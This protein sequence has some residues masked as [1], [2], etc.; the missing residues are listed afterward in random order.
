MADLLIRNIEPRLKR[1]IAESARKSRHSLSE[2]AKA[3]IQRGLATHEPVTKMGSFLF[4]LFE[5]RD[6]GD[7][8]VFERN[9]V[10][11]PPRNFE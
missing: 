9:D 10:V 2:E 3:L 6:R 7:D 4:S 8:L 1:R 5:D 11:S